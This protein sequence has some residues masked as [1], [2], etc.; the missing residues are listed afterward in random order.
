M[1]ITL[2]SSAQ[3]K[4]SEVLENARFWH[5]EGVYMNSVPV[6]DSL[7]KIHPDLLEA[8]INRGI[9]AYYLDRYDHAIADLDAAAKL[10]PDSTFVLFM[11]GTSYLHAGYEEKAL[12]TFSECI[13][14][15]KNDVWTIS[16]HSNRGVV[17]K[18][19]NDYEAAKL[20][21]LTVLESGRVDAGFYFNYANLENFHGD[22]EKAILF[23]QKSIDLD[24]SMAPSWQYLGHAHMDIG[25]PE[26]ALQAYTRADKIE[27]NNSNT[28]AEMG[29]AYGQLGQTKKACS[30]LNRAAELGSKRAETLRAEYCK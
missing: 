25:D 10:S 27:P 4:L 24:P 8:L 22:K 13:D 9:G 18:R 7:L 17:Y 14:I 2:S 28:L 29:M 16:S 12:K 21:Y 20:D 30:T 1:L 6:Y 19:L 26:K 23:Y 5:E 11:L 15:G 3:K